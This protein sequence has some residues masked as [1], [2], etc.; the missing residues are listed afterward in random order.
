MQ[1]CERLVT[2]GY[3]VSNQPARLLAQ[4]FSEMQ[5]CKKPV[6]GSST[7]CLAML[8]HADGKL[9]SA[10]IG[11]SGLLVVRD[12]KVVHRSSEQQHYFN[13]PF[14][15]S[16]PPSEMASDVL[17]DQP[18]AAD[19]YEFNVEDGDVIVLATDGVF[20]NVPDALLVEQIS[21]IKGCTNDRVK[22][23]QCCNSIAF[24]ARQLSRDENFLSPF[25]KNARRNGYSEV[26]GGKEDDVT[27]LLAAVNLGNNH[28]NSSR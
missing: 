9:Y 26:A 13:T 11:D 12:D 14:Q 25:A 10:N 4:G 1:S 16:L 28:K 7:A 22:I 5:E 3:F 23:Q 24:L 20:D 2:S 15:L 6:I 17:S 27:V 21:S 8:S 18:E 19:R